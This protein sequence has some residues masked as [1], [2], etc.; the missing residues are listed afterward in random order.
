MSNYNGT[1]YAFQKDFPTFPT[2]K[3]AMSSS[4]IVHHCVNVKQSFALISPER[5]VR[6][7]KTYK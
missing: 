6:A 7:N 5:V 2:W 3:S 1:I 4:E